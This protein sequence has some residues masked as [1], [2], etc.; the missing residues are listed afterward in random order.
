M[1]MSETLEELVRETVEVTGTPLPGLLEKDAPILDRAAISGDEPGGFYL[2]GLIGGKEVGKSA[3]VNAL[4][5]QNVTVSTAFGPGTETAIAY[6]HASQ[7]SA[8]AALLERIVPGRFRVVKHQ[9][10]ELRGLA[11][12][13]LPDIDS[14]YRDHLQTTRA[15]LRHLLFPVWVGS[16]EKY[17]D[18]QPMRLLAQVATGNAP[19]NFLFCLNKG[20][21]L[22]QT[23]EQESSGAGEGKERK[24]RLGNGGP[25]GSN[26]ISSQL[27]IP[28]PSSSALAE[29]RGDYASRIA[30]TLGLASEPR[31][32]VISAIQPERFDLP[33]LRRMLMRAKAESVV[34]ESKELAAQRQE[35]SLLTWLGT[36]ELPVRARRLSR[37]REEAEELLSSRLGPALLERVAPKLAGDASA[38]LAIADEVLEERVAR[39]P[40]V[41]LVHTLFSPI[42]IMARGMTSRQA[43]APGSAESLVDVCLRETDEPVATLLQSAF[44]QLRRS[45]PLVGELYAANKLWESA[46]A[47]AAA[48]ELSRRLAQT[49]IRQRSFVRQRMAGAGALL[50]MP[51]RWL[52]TIGAV[53]WFPFVQPMLSG[54]LTSHLSITSFAT[55][56]VLLIEVLSAD[57]LLKSTAFLFIWFLVLW[58]ALRWNT[59]RKV[60]RLVQRWALTDVSDPSVNLTTQIMQWMEDLLAPIRSSEQRFESLAKRAQQFDASS[61]QAG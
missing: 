19:E 45:H 14:H 55:A 10:A 50:G 27:S 52:L 21:Q 23:V 35:R 17:A 26:S 3:L 28:L 53:L 30:R 9:V 39:W 12:L 44:G 43:V 46:A 11:L 20:D 22:A 51:I 37:L 2:V 47:D 15:V 54:A 4:A 16:V 60:A 48:G 6:A 58:L 13:D 29:L 24:N 40:I 41:N 49:L 25:E 33:E 61:R 36:Q 34:K 42:L 38:K 5:G 32:F 18:Q 31:V 59:Q 1:F 8:V 56:G 7:E 57:Y